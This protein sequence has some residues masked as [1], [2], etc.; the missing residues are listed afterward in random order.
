MVAGS[1]RARAAADSP[2]RPSGGGRIPNR[3]LVFVW[4]SA[5]WSRLLKSIVT[6][7]LVAI[8]VVVPIVGLYA[9]QTGADGQSVQTGPVIEMTPAP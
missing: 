2:A 7:V 9:W 8:F 1:A 3:H 5:R 4:L 6:V